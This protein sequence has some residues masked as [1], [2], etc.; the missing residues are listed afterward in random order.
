MTGPDSLPN[1][2]P[3]TWEVSALMLA[4]AAHR[5]DLA[6]TLIDAGADPNHRNE[7]GDSALSLARQSGDADLL[8]LVSAQI[9]H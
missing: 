6:R 2:A 1:A 9:P 5:Q 3:T 8:A 7:K 4:V